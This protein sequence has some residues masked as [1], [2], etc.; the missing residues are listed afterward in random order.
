MDKINKK[1]KEF[2]K[3]FKALSNEKPCLIS[4]QD[5]RLRY[6]LMKEENEEYLQACDLNDLIE[7]A[8]ACI[9]K[10]YILLGTMH[11]HGILDK[12]EVLFNE[13]HRSNMSKLDDDGKPIINGENG[14]LDTTRPLG[15]VLK[16][17]NFS[18]PNLELFLK[19]YI[20]K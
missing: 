17:E 1:V 9:D 11:A 5:Y 15:K 4:K 12:A 7:I 13:V 2:A 20:N 6:E 8:D 10:L 18:K 16:S 19:K 14:V 3:A